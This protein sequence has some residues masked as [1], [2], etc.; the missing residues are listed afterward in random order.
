MKK[1]VCILL[2]LCSFACILGC[3]PEPPPEDSV[4]VYYKR[5]Q[6]VY[7]AADGVIASTYMNAAD[8]EDDYAYLLVKYFRTAPGE[9][10]AITFPDNLSV[11]SIQ[12]EGL[13]A[14]VILS[15]EITALT[16]MDL[17]IA[18]VCLTQTLIGLTDC[19]EVIISAST[20]QLDGQNFITL[21]RDSYLLIDESGSTQN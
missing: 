17:T 8:H 5:D 6:A 19:Q 21:N 4:T 14:K 16:G 7:G 12:L 11:V 20:Q 9:G 3:T 10:F 13:T 1:I 18:L 2:V 15:D